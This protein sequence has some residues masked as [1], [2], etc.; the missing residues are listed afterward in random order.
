MAGKKPQDLAP[1]VKKRIGLIIG[2]SATLNPSFLP[3]LNKHLRHALKVAASASNF[4]D[5]GEAFVLAGGDERAVQQAVRQFTVTQK[6]S[7]TIAQLAEARLNAVLSLS[8]DQYLETAL[9][10]HADKNPGQPKIAAVND[11]RALAPPKS[12]PV[13]KLM[14]S[15]ARDDFA[16]TRVTYIERKAVWRTVIR[17]FAD[18][19]RGAPVLCLGVTECDWLFF[20]L[21]GEMRADPVALPSPLLMLDTEPLARS[22]STERLLGPGRLLLVHGTAGE[23]IRAGYEARAA[24]RRIAVPSGGGPAGLP[25]LA[26]RQDIVKIVNLVTQSAIAPSE[27][28]RL[29]SILFSPSLPAWDPFVHNLD[30]VRDVTPELLLECKEASLSGPGDS[31]IAL[32]GAASCGKTTVLKR[33]AL[34]LAKQGET[35]LWLKPW[36]QPDGRRTLADFFKALATVLGRGARKT[37]LFV[38]D[39][40]ALG[41]VTVVDALAAADQAGLELVVVAA[42]RNSD[43]DGRDQGYRGRILG[44]VPPRAQI[45]VP[46]R[47]TSGELATFPAYL[48]KLNAAAHLPDAEKM[49]NEAAQRNASDILATLRWLLPDTRSHITDSVREEYFRLGDL[50]G[51]SKVI[52]GK[53]ESTSEL[54]Q[55]A[56]RMVAVAESFRQPLPLEVLVSA[57]RVDYSEWL[58]VHGAQDGVFGLLYMAEDESTDG[59]D[60]DET[61]LY[62]TRNSVVADIIV[63]TVN[64]GTMSHGGELAVLRSLLT[65]CSGTRPVYREFCVR[66]LTRLEHYEWLEFGEGLQLFEAAM[67][68]LPFQDRTLVHQKAIWIRKRGRDPLTAITVMKEA[69]GTANYPSAPRAETDEHI[70]TS[71]ARATLDA[72]ELLRLDFDTGKAQVMSYLAK[73]RSS[74]FFNPSAAHVQASL[75]LTLS[76]TLDRTAAADYYQL[77]NTALADVDR[78]LV[79]LRAPRAYRPEA[80]QE[81]RQMLTVARMQLLSKVVYSKDLVQEADQLWTEHQ[82]Q[83]GFVYVARHML[84][85]A[86]REKDSGAEFKAAFDYV[87]DKLAAVTAAQAVPSA[88]LHEVALHI[89]YRW[90]VQRDGK[91]GGPVDWEILK[92][93]AGELLKSPRSA[94]DALYLYLEGLAL[95]HLGQWGEAQ[96]CFSVLRRQSMPNTIL[97]ATR[98]SLLDANGNI[99]TVQG[100]VR[101]TGET[102]FIS[103][104]DPATAIRADR[105]SQWPDDGTIVHVRIDFSFAGPT[106]VRVSS[107]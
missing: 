88:G 73:A 98:D 19:N 66:I 8:L 12:L 69:L 43:W 48:V 52:I 45:S 6:P 63:S 102:V 83:D 9:Q 56:Y 55:R 5:T 27:Q 29:L 74:T 36:D 91:L 40:P 24:S 15:S 18:A 106:A 93:Y 21:L 61:L 104:D 107:G 39:P 75:V 2:P 103:C 71:L 49:T 87:Q 35:V 11:L 90:R 26:D 84:Q 47:F 4:L 59:D 32:L 105:K 76:D 64:G 3:D 78:T 7:P 14:G 1:L 53:T 22:P 99:R 10:E 28:A 34:E 17:T 25:A 16:C 77:L 82:S 92:H 57:L 96:A 44:P 94:Q 58:A 86:G 51:L 97:H 70:Y 13:F 62:R 85:R 72:M 41:A 37:F 60:G 67:S 79:M 89:Y 101:R 42:I 38:D 68:A 81:D 20:D 31:A 54:L 46:N 23:L 80:D 30:F 100:T 95:A 50:A 33:A 65:A